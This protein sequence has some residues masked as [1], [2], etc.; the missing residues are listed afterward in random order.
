MR[1]LAG[2][3]GC[4]NSY[5]T[6]LLDTLEKQ[7]LAARESHPTDRRIKVIV[8]T[9]EGRQVAEWVQRAYATPPAAFASLSHAES[10]VLCEPLRKVDRPAPDDR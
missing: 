1:Q 8:L 3:I 10:A 7:G 5:V 6:P 4:E 9:E 2:R